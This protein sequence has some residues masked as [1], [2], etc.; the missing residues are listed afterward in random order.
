MKVMLNF[1]VEIMFLQDDDG[2]SG[3]EETLRIIVSVQAH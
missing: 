2:E 1:S 3:E